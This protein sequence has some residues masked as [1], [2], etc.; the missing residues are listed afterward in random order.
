V[1]PAAAQFAPD[2]VLVSAGFDAH[3]LDP[4]ADCRLT[5]GSFAQMS[6]LVRD[7]AAWAGAPLGLV[8]EGGYNR[9]VL[10]ECVC[11][12]LPALAGEGRPAARSTDLEGHDAVL[13]DRALTQVGRYWQL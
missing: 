13:L 7:F 10:A 12:V 4:L 2:L 6:M 8:L 1:L 11:A 5:T 3:E 9:G